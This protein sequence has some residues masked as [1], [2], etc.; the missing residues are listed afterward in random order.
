MVTIESIAISVEGGR[1]IHLWRSGTLREV[2][3][4]SRSILCH[5]AR[6]S[7]VTMFKRSE[8]SIGSIGLDFFHEFLDVNLLLFDYPHTK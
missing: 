8:G 3:V 6:R 7:R 2:L 5:R 1:M 4:H